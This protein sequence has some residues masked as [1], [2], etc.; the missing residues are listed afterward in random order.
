MVERMSVPWTTRFR[1]SARV[2][3]LELEP[4]QPRPEP[5]VAGGR[6]LR[7]EPADLLDRARE[8]HPRALEQQLAREQRAVE[9]ARREDALR[10][11]R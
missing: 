9:L 7:L 1:S 3:S 2:R 8:R 5:D 11:R 4:L 10:Q 6:V